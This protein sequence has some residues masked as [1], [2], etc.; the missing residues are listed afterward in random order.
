MA[1]EHKSRLERICDMHHNAEG[2][3][4]PSSS[5]KQNIPFI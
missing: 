4:S 3:F 1:S 2:L 5:E